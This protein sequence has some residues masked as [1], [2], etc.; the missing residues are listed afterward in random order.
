V[1]GVAGGI[2]LAIALAVAA[3]AP[4]PYQ[5]LE[6][7][8]LLD[9]AR[10]LAAQKQLTILPGRHVPED[11]CGRDAND[12]RCAVWAIDA[13]VLADS[14]GNEQV[15][16]SMSEGIA[17]FDGSDQLIA[18]NE[19]GI[20]PGSQSDVIELSAGQVVPDRD[21]ELVW[22]WDS[23]GRNN[24]SSG[25]TV[26]KRRGATLIEVFNGETRYW[27]DLRAPGGGREKKGSVKL[28]GA[29]VIIAR[30]PNEKRASIWHWDEH[31]FH[32]VKDGT[33]K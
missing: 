6:R 30:G 21:L 25:I 19:D 23:G 16:A 33:K 14:P 27:E 32:F 3:D 17:L 8:R 20:D 18:R 29:G 24:G 10:Q 7:A 5:P 15:R 9:E 26:Y 31:A 1:S 11:G 28:T 2:V 22:S 12:V 13:D 4:A